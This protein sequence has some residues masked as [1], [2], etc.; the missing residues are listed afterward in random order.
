MV[1]SFVRKWCLKTARYGDGIGNNG[2]PGFHHICHGHN[3]G[4][5]IPSAYATGKPFPGIAPQCHILSKNRA[6]AC[7]SGI[8]DCFF[9][10][11]T[12]PFFKDLHFRLCL[13]NGL[14]VLRNQ[15]KVLKW[16]MTT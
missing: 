4:I 3:R 5:E 10:H 2:G 14:W 9:A 12:P 1:A 16:L 7:P 11:L 8:A 6:N 15:I 13:Q